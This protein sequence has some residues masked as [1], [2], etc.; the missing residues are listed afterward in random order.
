M[1]MMS[2]TEAKLLLTYFIIEI[3]RRLNCY[4]LTEMVGYY[5]I[6]NGRAAVIYLSWHEC[7]KHVLGVSNAI[8]K[9][10]STYE[11]AVRE[12]EAA[13]R[14]V[15]PNLG[16]PEPNPHDAVPLLGSPDHVAASTGAG[17]HGCSKVVLIICVAILL[18]G[19]WLFMHLCL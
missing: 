18:V 16:E 1:P 13:K 9:K 12:F 4:S 7:G 2:T 15:N 8:Y 5:V 11:E 6:F 3:L 19:L 14:D 10:Y 17:N